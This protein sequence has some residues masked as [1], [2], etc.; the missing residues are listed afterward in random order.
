M[1]EFR[2][3]APALAVEVVAAAAA[4]VATAAA[5]RSHPLVTKLSGDVTCA[6]EE[7]CDWARRVAVGHGAGVR[8]HV[9]SWV[10]LRPR[11]TCRK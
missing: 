6:E 1:A 9:S 2:T 7:S 11:T 5:A 4:A 10:N 8:A 3:N